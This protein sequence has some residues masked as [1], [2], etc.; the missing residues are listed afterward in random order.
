[1]SALDVP[2]SAP[3]PVFADWE[4]PLALDPSARVPPWP[5]HALRGPLAEAVSEVARSTQ[6]PRD[7]A[8][9]LALAALSVGWA[10][11]VVVEVYP[12]YREPLMLYV[13]V[14]A[15]SGERKSAVFE[16][17]SA[18]IWATPGPLGAE[19]LVDDA[20]PEALEAL[21]ARCGGKAAVFGPEGGAFLDSL[22]ARQHSP[23]SAIYLKGHTGERHSAQRIKRETPVLERPALTI[24]VMT[25][26]STLRCLGDRDRREELLNRGFTGRVLFACPQQRLAGTL[27]PMVAPMA[28]AV[29][30]GYAR[31]LGAALAVPLLP[32]P[33]V[34]CFSPGAQ[35][36]YDRFFLDI[37]A[38]R[39]EG[40][41]LARLSGWAPKLR[42]NVMRI[43]ALLHLSEQAAHAE[44]W[45]VPVPADVM[46]RAR[47]LSDYF[48]AHAQAAFTLMSD[49]ADVACARKLLA[50]VRAGNRT[51]FT[52]REAQRHLGRAGTRA[53]VLD[54]ALEVLRSHGYLRASRRGLSDL[55]EVNPYEVQGW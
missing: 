2:A 4:V 54:P 32:A 17:M 36:E 45:C 52:A 9:T 30:E 12:G 25:Q 18:P 44:P 24:G 49:D 29:R 51:R 10:G 14:A 34:L 23:A 28:A 5:V 16:Y 48:I 15:Q 3:P 22:R 19:L 43:A 7:F 46:Q 1:M 47:L 53:R 42:G 13:V 50:W 20:T 8:G 38:R 6:T 40:G 55:F 21:M 35:A 26:P 41:A 31:V 33:R 11:K 37:E 27:Q 39:G